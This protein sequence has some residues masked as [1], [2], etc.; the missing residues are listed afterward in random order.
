MTYTI[1]GRCPRTGRLGIGIA[2]WSLGVGGY[3]PYVESNLGALSS[4]A[5][6]DPRL[7]LL[8]MRLLRRGHSPNEVIEDLRGHDPHFEYRQVGIVDKDGKAAVHTGTSTR[9]WTGHVT[10]DGY[11]AMGNNLDS[12]RVVQA[13]A[14]AFEASVD[15]DLDERLLMSLEAGRDAGGQN[16]AYPQSANQDRSAALIVYEQEEYALMDLRVDAHETAIQ[17]LRRVWDEYTPYIPLYYYLR[18]KEP[19]KVP[20]QDEWLAQQQAKAGT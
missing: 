13:M 5:G 19:D 4:Q 12:E 17:E 15:L 11:A 1:I 8:A 14:R 2:T 16:A 3:C 18:V 9:P 6:A 10:G 20:K 7:G